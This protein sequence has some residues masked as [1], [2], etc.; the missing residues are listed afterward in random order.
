MTK[1]DIMECLSKNYL[2]TVANKAGYFSLHGKD[3]GT[4]LHVCKATRIDRGGKIR[5]LNSGRQIQIQLKSVLEHNVNVA[6]K[7]VHYNLEA[8]NYDDLIDRRNES[9]SVIP[10]ILVVFIFPSKEDDWVAV[11]EDDLRLKR[12][13][14]W[15][16]PDANQTYTSNDA[17]QVI[18]IPKSNRIDL[19]FFPMIFNYFG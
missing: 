9:G 4:D 14:Y 2:E 11:T 8:K 7:D 13:A 12:H 18:K 1:T 19:D 5:L 16:Y 15:F 3:F 10:L 17:S 6:D